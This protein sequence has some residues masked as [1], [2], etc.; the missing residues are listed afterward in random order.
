VVVGDTE[1]GSVLVR[2]GRVV[3]QLDTVARLLRNKVGLG[4]PAVGA[5]VGDVL[6]NGV[7]SNGVGGWALE[8]QE[9][10]GTLS[11]GLPGDLVWLAYRHNVVLAGR[12]EVVAGWR[13]AG[14][15]GPRSSEGD[16][17]GKA[18]DDDF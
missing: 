3:N 2:A 11:G 12:V 17:A 16:S 4:S 6:D 10:D 5:S 7:L 15:L 13:L 8:E 1:L 18:S 9:S 14:G